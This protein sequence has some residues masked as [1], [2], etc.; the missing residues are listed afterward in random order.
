MPIRDGYSAVFVD[1]V[2]SCESVPNSDLSIYELP[3][4][5]RIFQAGFLVHDDEDHIVVAGGMKPDL[6]TYDY[7]IAIP[8]CAIVAIRYLTIEESE[9]SE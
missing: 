2:D 5:Q 6:E 3:S 7:V 8:R 1:W 9:I 4:P